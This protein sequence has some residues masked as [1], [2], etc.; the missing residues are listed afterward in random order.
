MTVN[1]SLVLIGGVVSGER[2][3]IVVIEIIAGIRILEETEVLNVHQ[4]SL[5]EAAA[6]RK[7]TGLK[8]EYD[9]SVL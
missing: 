1:H 4:V 3:R 7:P 6:K 9:C 8:P 2:I 5:S